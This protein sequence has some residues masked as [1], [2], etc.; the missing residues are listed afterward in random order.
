MRF[1]RN[2]ILIFLLKIIAKWNELSDVSVSLFVY[3][4]HMPKMNCSLKLEPVHCVLPWVISVFAFKILHGDSPWILSQVLLCM[5][6]D[7][8]LLNIPTLMETLTVVPV[9]KKSKHQISLKEINERH[10]KFRIAIILAFKVVNETLSSRLT[11]TLKKV[12]CCCK[13]FYLC[14]HRKFLF[15]FYLSVVKDIWK[16]CYF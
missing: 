14:G 16:Y 9:N 1:L 3:L 15:T 7:V 13:W 6:L 2:R 5:K 10:Y 4:S 12:Y 11:L 8:V